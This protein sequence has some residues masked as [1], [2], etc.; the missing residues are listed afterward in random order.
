MR[1][2]WARIGDGGLVDGCE[3]GMDLQFVHEP[4]LACLPSKKEPPLWPLSDRYR[5]EVREQRFLNEARKDADF[6]T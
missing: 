2:G 6:W 4:D 1:R 3:E 5:E